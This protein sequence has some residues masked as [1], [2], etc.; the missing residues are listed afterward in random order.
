M[1]VM[2]SQKWRD[3][4]ELYIRSVFDDSTEHDEKFRPNMHADMEF[5]RMYGLSIQ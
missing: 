1:Y 5:R 4:L 3:K 2:E